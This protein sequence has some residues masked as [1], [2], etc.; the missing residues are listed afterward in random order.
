[1]AK[2]KKKE[3][4]Y[5]VIGMIILFGGVLAAIDFWYSDWSG[6][7]NTWLYSGLIGAIILHLI[8]AAAAYISLREWRDY[9]FDVIRK[10]FC[11]F[12]FAAILYVGGFRA[13][14]NERQGVS[15]DSNQ[16]KQEQ[17]K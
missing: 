5:F 4:L 2:E 7:T 3:E 13:A 10:W 1:M 6:M 8:T 9:E 17:L 11:G 16:A 12:V 14:K 15:D